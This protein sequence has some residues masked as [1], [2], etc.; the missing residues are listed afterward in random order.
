MRLT[1][2]VTQLRQEECV[3]VAGREAAHEKEI[4]SAM[5]ISQ[6]WEDLTLDAEALSFK[7]NDQQGL[8]R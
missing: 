4:H 7:D 8:V 5:Q 3:D 1:P 2:R 6:S